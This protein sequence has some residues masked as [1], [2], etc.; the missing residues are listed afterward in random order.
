MREGGTA[1]GGAGDIGVDAVAGIAAMRGLAGGYQLILPAS[2]GAPYLV[3]TLVTRADDSRAITID[4]SSGAVVQD[5]DWRMFGPG[6]KA[7][8]WGIAT[9]QGQQYG[10]INRLLMLAGCLCL[11]ALCLTAPVLWWK[12]RKQGR[13]TAPPRATGRAERVVAATMLL[14]GALF[15]LTGLSMVVALAG[16]WLIGKMRPT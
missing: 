8:E 4:A 2:P 11:L 16:E 15:P 13:L 5:M 6:A 12:R 10:E 7:V 9:H 14:L 3:V 1:Q